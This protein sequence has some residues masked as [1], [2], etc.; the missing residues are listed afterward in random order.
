MTNRSIASQAL[1]VRHSSLLLCMLLHH[2]AVSGGRNPRRHHRPGPPSGGTTTSAQTAAM[3]DEAGQAGL[4]WAG[5]SA[6]RRAITPFPSGHVDGIHLQSTRHHRQ[7]VLADRV[8][9]RQGRPHSPTPLMTGEDAM[10][11]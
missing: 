2:T 1:R 8:N 4:G 5:L 10:P 9:G 7:P 3:N 11:W 6:P